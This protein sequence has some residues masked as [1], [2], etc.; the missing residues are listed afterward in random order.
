MKGNDSVR[1]QYEKFQNLNAIVNQLCASLSENH[2]DL[3]EQ[4]AFMLFK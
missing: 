3:L 2:R 4:I 1:E